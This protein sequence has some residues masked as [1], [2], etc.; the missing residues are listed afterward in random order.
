MLTRSIKSIRSGSRFLCHVKKVEPSPRWDYDA[1]IERMKTHRPEP[2]SGK[3][4]EKSF[5]MED[6]MTQIF[7]AEEEFERSSTTDM[8]YA[9]RQWKHDNLKKE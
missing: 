9:D 3:L 5:D 8:G 4:L 6:V 2:Y 7:E 1:A